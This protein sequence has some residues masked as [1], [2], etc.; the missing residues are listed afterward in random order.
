RYTWYR[1]IYAA[2]A[3]LME[4]QARADHVPIKI[5]GP[6]LAYYAHFDTWFPKFLNDPQ[7]APYVD[8]VTYH[9]Y[10]TGQTWG[11]VQGSTK[12]NAKVTAKSV[13][14]ATQDPAVGYTAI[15]EK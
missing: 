1:V 7:I 8:F 3:P 4:A 13:L 12:N 10:V 5:G 2:S 11:V 14:D 15:Y 9:Q 6:T